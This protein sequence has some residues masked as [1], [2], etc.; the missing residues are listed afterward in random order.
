MLIQWLGHSCFLLTAQNGTRLLTDP[1]NDKVG[2]PL[3]QVPAEVV[4]TS[5]QHG[6][7]NYIDAVQGKFDVIDR[8]GKFTSYGIEIQGFPTYHDPDQGT[9]RGSNILFR[10]LID[11]LAIVH[12]GDLGHVLNPEQ[13]KAIGHVDVL[14]VPVGGYYTID[15]RDAAEVMHRLH[16]TVTIPMHYNP[17]F[18]NMPIGP[19]DDFLQEAGGGRRIGAQSIE[20][21]LEKLHDQAGVVVLAPPKK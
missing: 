14:L 4:T 10:F 5:H 9:K 16:P 2:Y 1:F 18:L 7:H 15:A 17:G 6:D 21:T 8:T 3:P 20:I 13:V 12:C 19:V 11:G